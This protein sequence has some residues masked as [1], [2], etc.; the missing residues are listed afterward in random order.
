[1]KIID[2]NLLDRTTALA[3]ESPRLRMN[4]NFHDQLDNP[5]NRLINAMEPG[6]YL[7]PH[8]HCNPDRDE[9]FLLLRGKVAFFIFDNEGN[10]TQKLILSPLDG[11][12]GADIRAGV[13]HS[14]LVLEPGSVVYESK[15]GPYTPLSKENMAPWSPEAEDKA[16]VE[17]YL[18]KLENSLA[19]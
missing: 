8:R 2:K 10:I 11:V 9:S 16:A 13:W 4:H 5:L 1:M 3:K 7:R 19:E 17:R 12:Y 6:T 14:M 18:K 15:E